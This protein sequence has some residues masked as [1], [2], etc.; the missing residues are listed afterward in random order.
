MKEAETPCNQEDKNQEN[1]RLLILSAQEKDEGRRVR[2]ILK[3]EW[4]LVHH[5]IARAKYT[6][7]GI[8][9][10]GEE[11]RAD[12]VM[13]KGETLRV[14]IFEKKS[15]TTVPTEGPL[16][17]LYEDEDV[18][19][20]NKPAGVVVH[21]S[22]G[23][24]V[25]SLANYIAFHFQE[26][27]QE[28]EIRTVGRLDKDTSGVILYAKNRTAVSKLTDQARDGRHRKIYLALAA[29]TFPEKDG[30]IDMPIGR[31]TD[32][33]DAPSRD[34]EESKDSSE[35]N[36]EKSKDSSG[37]NDETSKD[38]SE[39]MKEES[40]ATLQQ[41]RPE[42]RN[43]SGQTAA[44]P[45]PESTRRCIRSDGD[46][47]VTHWH[48]EKQFSG[49]ALLSVTIDTGRTHQIRVHL[50][51]IGH[52]L[53]GDL[54][55]GGTPKEPADTVHVSQNSMRPGYTGQGLPVLYRTALHAWKVEFDQPFTGERVMLC[56]PLPEDMTR[57]TEMTGR[58]NTDMT[59]RSHGVHTDEKCASDDG[60]TSFRNDPGE[61]SILYGS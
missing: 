29:G 52:P 55:Y 26:E 54:L 2:E 22:H 25:D 24:Y 20:V 35:Q 11:V 21:P 59:R 42:L 47:A 32:R 17:I 48:L 8:T 33:R 1:G 12:H 44:Q 50:S 37:Q 7:G 18:I 56:A 10:D 58:Q 4:G 43:L 27:G 30:T 3:K 61:D 57:I 60:E 45:G 9:V 36:E 53:L 28:H 49:Y 51:S 6:P 46:P 5:D 19:A 14:F 40:R 31:V 39:Q 38:S 16:D 23:H 34:G 13:K 41:V 15:E